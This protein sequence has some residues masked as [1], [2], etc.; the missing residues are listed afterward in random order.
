VLSAPKRG[1]VGP[2]R[3]GGAAGEMWASGAG[4]EDPVEESEGW[5]RGE[6]VLAGKRGWR[7][8]GGCG[9]GWKGVEGDDDDDG[10]FAYGPPA[11]GLGVWG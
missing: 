11:A 6:L 1:S 8:E 5:T 2:G 10:G 3:V 7:G 9:C 4:K